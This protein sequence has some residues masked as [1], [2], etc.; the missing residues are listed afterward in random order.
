MQVAKQEAKHWYQVTPPGI[1]GNIIII[2]YLDFD[3]DEF[4]L[5]RF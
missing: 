4:G 2:I 1:R 3:F 5:L